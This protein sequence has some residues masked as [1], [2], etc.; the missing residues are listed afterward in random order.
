MADHDIIY[1]HCNQGIIIG[2]VL[3][4][5]LIEVPAMNSHLNALSTIG[6][7]QLKQ[8]VSYVFAM[9]LYPDINC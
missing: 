4:Y 6:P 3:G 9:S 1:M 5:E 2:A 8:Q 7:E